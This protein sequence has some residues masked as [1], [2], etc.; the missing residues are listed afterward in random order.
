MFVLLN[1]NEFDYDGEF[2]YLSGT[3]RADDLTYLEPE[4]LVYQDECYTV[5]SF[6]N[7]R[8]LEQRESNEDEVEKDW[9][10]LVE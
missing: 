9:E 4:H 2:G 7:Y 3:W 1:N 6:D 8:N 10:V 5:Y